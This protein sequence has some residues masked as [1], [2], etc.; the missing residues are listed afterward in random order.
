MRNE[1]LKGSMVLRFW[2]MVGVRGVHTTG[3]G[4]GRTQRK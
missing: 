1:L 3:G 2:T 4:V